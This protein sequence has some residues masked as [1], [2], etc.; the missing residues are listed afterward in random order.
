MVS[1]FYRTRWGERELFGRLRRRY[2]FDAKSGGS[3]FMARGAS[4]PGAGQDQFTWQC[5]SVVF[6]LLGFE[7]GVSFLLAVLY[8]RRARPLVVVQSL[9]AGLIPASSLDSLSDGR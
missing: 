5:N 9:A 3:Y 2:L 1:A 6:V 4:D 7:L 8:P